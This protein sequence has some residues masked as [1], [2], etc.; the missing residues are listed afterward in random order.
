MSEEEKPEART[1]EGAEEEAEAP[2]EATDSEAGA[3]DEKEEE[4]KPE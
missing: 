2:V 4:D 1:P 3:G